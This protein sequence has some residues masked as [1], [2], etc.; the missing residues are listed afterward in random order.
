MSSHALAAAAALGLALAGAVRAEEPFAPRRV[1]I[2]L[3]RLRATGVS[4]V[5][6]E[7][8]EERV[9]AVLAEVADADV[10]CPSDV[11]AAALI[12]RNAALFGECRSDDCM[13]RVEAVRTADRRVSGSLE[14]AEKGVVLSLQLSATDGPGTRVVEKLPEDLDEILARLPA[15]VRKLL[16]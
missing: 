4:Q 1:R 12:A 5:L 13:K 16:R 9:C 6:A 15:A 2:G 8:V 3:D 10:T 14:R 11:A 7:A